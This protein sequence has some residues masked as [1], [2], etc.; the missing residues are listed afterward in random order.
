[1]ETPDSKAGRLTERIMAEVKK[2][3]PNIETHAYNRTYEAV[4]MVL[5]LEIGN[6]S[7]VKFPAGGGMFIRR[8]KP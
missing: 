3:L 6:S 2:R 5:E 7:V 1:M 8:T 4:L